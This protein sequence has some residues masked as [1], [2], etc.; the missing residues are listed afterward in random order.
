MKEWQSVVS[1]TDQIIEM[2]PKSVKAYYFRGKAFVE[3]QE[4]DKAFECLT[5][6]CEIDPTNTDSKNELA[7]IKR[8]RKDF[9][10]K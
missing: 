6:S 2:D 1:I 9:V 7:R 4:Y 5:K 3:L 8:V 10:E